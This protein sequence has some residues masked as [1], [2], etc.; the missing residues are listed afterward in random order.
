MSLSG[1]ASWK[2]KSLPSLPYADNR[3]GAKTRMRRTK[4]TVY[5]LHSSVRLISKDTHYKVDENNYLPNRAGLR[6]SG[7]KQKVE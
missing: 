2:V 3:I 7:F 4:T 1:F 6:T 5:G